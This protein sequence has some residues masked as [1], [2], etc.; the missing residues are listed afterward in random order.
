[1]TYSAFNLSAQVRPAPAAAAG[2]A[3]AAAFC[4]ASGWWR[5]DWLWVGL[6]V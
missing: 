2:R 3:R 6:W 1:M 4:C 5:Y